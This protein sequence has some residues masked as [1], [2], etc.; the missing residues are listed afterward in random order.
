MRRNASTEHTI[1]KENPNHS[2]VQKRNDL[3]ESDSGGSKD[4]SKYYAHH[5]LGVVIAWDKVLLG[6]YEHAALEAPKYGSK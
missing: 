4:T 2:P 1:E 3:K 6:H 5:N